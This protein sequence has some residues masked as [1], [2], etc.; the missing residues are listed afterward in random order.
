[1]TRITFRTVLV[2]LG[3]ALNAYGIFILYAL[4]NGLTRYTFINHNVAILAINRVIL[5]IICGT[6]ALVVSQTIH[7]PRI[8]QFHAGTP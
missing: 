3:V 8:D 1:M 7:P 6:I 2:V 5:S 4:V